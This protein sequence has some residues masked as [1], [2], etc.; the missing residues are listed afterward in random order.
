[1]SDVCFPA[2]DCGVATSLLLP[3][4][5]LYDSLLLTKHVECDANHV[6]SLLRP[7]VTL[8]NGRYEAEFP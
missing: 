2:I 4:A 3:M 6:L 8:H 7:D 1:M 5:C